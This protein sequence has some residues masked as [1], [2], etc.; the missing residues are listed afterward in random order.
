MITI[1]RNASKWIIVL[2][3]LLGLGSLP[4]WAAVVSVGNVT[5][6]TVST[7]AGTGNITA[8]FA[9]STGGSVEITP[10]APDVVRVDFHWVGVFE[11]DQPM[12]AKSFTNWPAVAATVSDLGSTFVIQTAQLDVELVKSPCKVHFKDKN[13]FYLLQDD[14]MEFDSAYN[15][16]GQRGT[17]SSK[18]K[19]QKVMPANQAYFGLG[20]YGGPM[21]R[22]GKEIDCWNTGTYNWSEYQNPTYLN[23]PF[24]YGV[25]PANGGIPAFVYGLFFNNPCRPLFKFGTQAGDKYSF[26]A[27]DG[28]LDYFF[29]GGGAGHTM[30]KVID[31]YS[32]LIGRPTM[33]PKWG[34]GH[35]L[36]RFSYDSQSW[37]EYI[38]NQATV[39]DFPLDAVYMDIDYMDADADGDFADGQ[40]HQ[41]TVN[42]RFANPAGMISYCNTRGVK[43]VP[44]IEPW[45]EPGDTTHYTEANSNLHFIKENSGA[46]VT[47]NIYVGA[48]SWFDYSSA[49]MNTWWQDRIVNWFNNV[50]F[51]GIWNDLTEPEGGDQIPHDALLWIDGKFGTSTTDSRRFWSNERNYFGLRCAR[52][53]YNTMLAKDAN[54]RPF[55]LS[56]SGNAGLQRFGVSWSGDTRANWFYQRATIRFGMGA[57]ISGAAWYGND[58]GGFAGTPSSELMVRSTEYNCLAP[59]FRNHAD[60]AAADREPWRFSE[61]YKSQMRDLIKMRYRLMP[62][63]YTLAYD[64]T[65][66]GEPM[67]VP[68]V[69]DYF[70]DANTHSQ[71]DYDFL[72]GDFI[73]AAPVYNEGATT[74]TTYLPYAD[75][76]E[77]YYWPSAQPSSQPSGDKYGGGQQVTVSAPLGKMPM[78]V[79]SGAIIPMGPSMQY[80]NQTQAAWMDINCWPHGDSEFTL[81]EDD[82][83]TW[84][85]LGGEYAQRRM[86]S[87]RTSS[88]WEFTIEAKQG[89]Y[90]TGAR[91][92]YVYCFN[93]GTST[94]RGVTLNGSSLSQLANFDAGP[95]G[96]MFTAEGRLGI[97]LPDTG[98]VAALR[99]NFADVN[100]TVQFTS[101]TNSAVENSGS[102][103]LYVSRS[104]SATG[105][106]SVSYAT[107]NGTATAGTDY[108]ATNG[109]LSWIA[110][111][112]ANKFF[113]VLLADDA[114]YEV[115]ETFSASLSA[116]AGADL[117]TPAQTIVTIT[118]DEPLPPDLLVTNP[119]G[120]ILVSEATTNYN[121]LGVAN[122]FNWSGLTW[123]NGLTGSSG[124]FPIGFTWAL[125]GVG[126]GIGTNLITITATNVGGPI[127]YDNGADA[128]YSD[129]WETNDHGGYGWGDWQF[130]TSSANPSENG[131]FMANSASVNIGAPAW[132]LYANNGSL[133]EAKRLLPGA[134]QVGQILSV[135]MDN[136]FINAG[137]GVGV[138]MQNASGTTLWEFF[139]NGGDTFYSM[140]GTTTDV[141]WTSSGIDVEFTLTSPTTY[142]TRVTP[143]G[144][145]TRTNVGNLITAADTNI[146]VFRAWNYNAG[147][148]SDYD[149][150]FN[151]LVLSGAGSSGLSTSVVVQ[152]VRAGTIR[153]I[154]QAWIDLY[155]LTG[156]NSGDDENADGDGLSNLQE[157]WADTNPTNA[158]SRFAA[159]VIQSSNTVVGST[160]NIVVS[161]PTTNSRLYDVS[162]GSN[163]TDGLWTPLGR[164]FP[165][166][167]DGGGLTFTI[168]NHVDSQ[169]YFRTRVFMP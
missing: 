79:R 125:D 160:I 107:A 31:R 53:S 151:D 49:A 4:A 164:N 112:L 128:A 156:P 97:K 168:T 24:F 40:L 71:S 143:M 12:I 136:G 106:V 3:C 75:G 58:V 60:K 48:V 8:S 157:Y 59:Y 103:R 21:N 120:A 163:L 162:Y 153:Q 78:F 83:E 152:I 55:V 22:R 149:C 105:A 169:L 52:Q 56:R 96:W 28:R 68:P 126:L 38:A 138:A 129:G 100:D 70:G 2:G 27:G 117:G 161:P 146:T 134:L 148:G 72:V 114:A 65:Q 165:G 101:A 23:I 108:T 110:G 14:R 13:G 144:G 19:C 88:A 46:T 6:V 116:A 7:N 61:P 33:L 113:D 74:R 84:D 42:S 92:F 135:R 20:E 147:I 85:Y 45:L 166:R 122:S 102:V 104:G 34:L 127:A 139:F 118:D 66:T 17:S 86:V 80:A 15:F 98:A 43:V 99:I 115:S 26:E 64:S 35:H 16:T 94:V 87:H 10:F 132:G 93:P 81:H 62:Y 82:G 30:A 141:G 73:L 76:V 140:S 39:D 77:W 119:P 41:L 29:I 123:S 109:T 44:L 54:K 67:N 36:S 32:E 137:S 131:R 133:S 9:L 145:N 51:S 155:Q 89:T 57:M 142:R 111:D 130:Y 37:I 63:L 159:A 1:K 25:Q 47:R 50:G 150:F 18:L 154:P 158:N 5:G 90:N 167:A 95:Q 91:D 121:I 69:F 11:T 124:Q